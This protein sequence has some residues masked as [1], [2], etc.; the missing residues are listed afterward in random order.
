MRKTWISSAHTGY[1]MPGMH[2]NTLSAFWLAAKKGADMIETDVRTSRDGVFF[3]N[4]DPEVRGFDGAGA[5]VRYVISETDSGVLRK[6]VMAPDDPFGVQYLPTLNETLDLAYFA[7]LQVNIDLKEGAMHAE[8][9]ARLVC[10]YG[11]RGR[12]VYATNGSGAVTILKILAIDPDAR[13]IDTPDHYT[14]E[15]LLTVPDYRKRCF[16]YT[17]DF[18]AENIGRI[19]AS[20]CMLA[21]ISLNAANAAQGLKWHPEMAEYPH[22]G[23]FE[24]IDRMILDKFG[25]I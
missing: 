24:A 12:V 3:V 23:D 1:V 13:F 21:S 6:V 19:R 7:G 2:A 15:A 18:S 11:M 25:K 16:A 22:T 20:G 14:R 10:E 4:H 17:S 8:D 5:P 9:I